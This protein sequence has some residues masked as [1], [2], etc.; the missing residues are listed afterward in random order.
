M[1]TSNQHLPT[2]LQTRVHNMANK[3]PIAKSTVK[4]ALLDDDDDDDDDD[5]CSFLECSHSFV[6]VFIM[7]RAHCEATVQKKKKKVKEYKHNGRFCRLSNKKPSDCG[8]AALLSW[9]SQLQSD[10]HAFPSFTSN[11][12]GFLTSRAELIWDIFTCDFRSYI[13]DVSLLLDLKQSINQLIDF[14]FSHIYC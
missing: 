3:V 14:Y 7:L 6:H 10:R 9:L 13:S 11:G 5:E 12:D 1:L 4:L 2:H 8:R